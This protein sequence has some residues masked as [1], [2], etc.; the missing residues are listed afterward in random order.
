[1]K[2]HKY[3][4]IVDNIVFEGAYT[5]EEDEPGY[6]PIVTLCTVE[7]KGIDLMLVIDPR[8]VHEIEAALLADYQWNT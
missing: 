5:L 4:Q 3:E 1:M 7:V 2:K 6:L 8:V